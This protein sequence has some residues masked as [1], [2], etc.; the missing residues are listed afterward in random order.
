M[1][2]YKCGGSYL[3]GSYGRHQDLECGKVT[4]D[5]ADHAAGGTE[6]ASQPADAPDWKQL[7]AGESLED[8]V[9]F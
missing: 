9:G 8:K 7:A 1:H 5:D 2:C 6:E 4:P 3:R